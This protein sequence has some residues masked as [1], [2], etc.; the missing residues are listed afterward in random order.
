[1]KFSVIIPAYNAVPYIGRCL[2]C[3]PSRVETV[4]VDDGSA[5]GTGRLVAGDFPGVLLLR[6]DNSGVS[7]AR[8]A[9]L[10]RVT[11][12]Y[13][14]FVDADDTLHPEAFDLLPARLEE[15]KADIVILRSFCDGTERYPWYG[16]FQEGALYTKQNLGAEAYVRGSVCGCVFRREYLMNNGFQFREGVSIAEDTLFFAETVSG[17]GRVVFLDI[18]FYEVF[19]RADSASLRWTPD[20]LSRYGMAVQMAASILDPVIRTQTSFSLILGIIDTGIRMGLRPGQILRE[21]G[22]SDI[23]PLSLKGIRKRRAAI[24]LLNASFSLTYWLKRLMKWVKC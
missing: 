18:P 12:E 13:V 5:D 4:V 7:M 16:S 14:L 10:R 11:G 6:Q 1:M 3:I 9:G 19:R 24:R 17:G 20:Y 23:L 2:S 8:N 21:S 15:C 22:V